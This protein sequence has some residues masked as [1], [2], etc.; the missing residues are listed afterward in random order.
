MYRQIAVVAHNIRS[1][2][3]VGSLMRTIDGLGIQK[4]YLTGYTPYPQKKDDQR[5]PHEY[6]KINK[7]INK[8]ALGAELNINWSH[9][10]GAIDVLLENLKEKGYQV[11][12]LEQSKESIKLTDY[13]PPEKIVLILGSE[14]KGIDPAILDISDVVV[15]IPMLGLKESYNV[16]L[17]AAMTLYSLRFC[18]D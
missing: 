14:I 8:T 3:N 4:L 17:A 15:E 13:V 9:Y 18:H 6:I 5:L 7:Q 16:T 11:C 12:A 2:H 10:D 1:I